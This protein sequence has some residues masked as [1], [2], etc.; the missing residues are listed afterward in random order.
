[1]KPLQAPSAGDATVSAW[2]Y[3]FNYIAPMAHPKAMKKLYPQGEPKDIPN[4]GPA[5]ILMRVRGDGVGEV[6]R[7]VRCVGGWGR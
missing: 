2:A 6:L 4:T 7:R 3:P 5:P 1:M